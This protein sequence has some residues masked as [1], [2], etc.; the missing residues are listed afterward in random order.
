MPGTMSGLRRAGHA[1]TWRDRVTTLDRNEPQTGQP[2]PR[3][4]RW[5]E[6]SEADQSANLSG[7]QP[8]VRSAPSGGWDGRAAQPGQAPFPGQGQPGS[9]PPEHAP[10]GRPPHGAPAGP[11]NGRPNTDSRWAGGPHPGPPPPGAYPTGSNARPPN[12]QP[13]YQQPPPWQGQHQYPP[14]HVFRGQIAQGQY[15]PGYGPGTQPPG[16]RPAGPGAGFPADA[17][18]APALARRKKASIVPAL[19]FGLLAVILGA[20]AIYLY[21]QERD[22]NNPIAPTAEPAQNLY[23]NVSDALESTG[24]TVVD[25]T[26]SDPG[27]KSPTSFPP[28]TVGQYISVEG[29]DAWMYIFTGPNSF[30]NQQ[31]ATAAFS[32]E[33]APPPVM[34]ASRTPLTTGPPTLFSGSNVVILLSMDDNPSDDIK[35]KIQEAVESLP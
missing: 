18:L 13:P 16:G 32:A 4:P 26:R 17:P 11:P 34:T 3:S 19:V 24:L 29:H 22:T 20:V 23:I 31:A 8:P 7:D 25:A 5:G 9:Y 27:A 21:V 15:T 6:V 12:G 35:A 2:R 1:L 33:D 14:G 28:G 30:A 10:F